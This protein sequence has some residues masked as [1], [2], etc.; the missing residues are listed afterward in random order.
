MSLK[1]IF[2]DIDDTLFST[3]EFADRARRGAVDAMRRYGLRLP[4]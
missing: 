3:T 1:A 2:F 4:A